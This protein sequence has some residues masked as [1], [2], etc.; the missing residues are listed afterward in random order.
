[1]LALELVFFQSLV[2]FELVVFAKNSAHV[3][4]KF[5]QLCLRH[6]ILL[7]HDILCC[8]VHILILTLNI[9]FI[10]VQQFFNL[11]LMDLFF[12]SSQILLHYFDGLVELFDFIVGFLVFI[13]I[14]LHNHIRL[15]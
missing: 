5:F 2:P 15:N 13:V 1:L 8:H 10:V 7:A 12:L 9:D 11:K 6:C 3:L 4:V 14:T